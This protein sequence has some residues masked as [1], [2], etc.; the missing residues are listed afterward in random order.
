MLANVALPAFLPHAAA[1]LVGIFVI[2]AIE[3]WFVMSILNL[4]YTESY[5]HSLV[6]NW[7]STMAGIPLAWL[8]WIAGLIPITMGLSALGVFSH[9]AVQSTLLQT[10]LFG[11]MMP[12]EWMYVGSAAAWIIMLVPFWLGSVWIERRTLKKRLPQCDPAQV[13]KAVIRG[14]L[15]SY[16]LFLLIGIVSLSA[17]LAD[18]PNQRARFQE[19]EERRAQ[20][21]QHRASP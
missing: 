13:S 21:N 15:V 3:G 19:I 5:R 17:A 20:Q 1:T 16:S 11:G 12:T 9:P 14:N 7:M 18:L 2:A 10:A 8:L 4:K 6:A